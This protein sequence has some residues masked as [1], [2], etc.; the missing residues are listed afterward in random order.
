ME[1]KVLVCF[2]WLEIAQFS[3]TSVLKN[4]NSLNLNAK[5]IRK[6]FKIRNFACHNTHNTLLLKIWMK[7]SFLFNFSKNHLKFL[8][9]L[10]KSL[11][12][13]PLYKKSVFALYKKYD[14]ISLTLFSV[15]IFHDNKM[16][17]I[18]ITFFRVEKYFHRNS[19]VRK[20]VDSSNF[21]LLGLVA[22]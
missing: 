16:L 14:D 6:S 18:R 7:I 5:I 20:S 10:E 15:I 12:F 13:M 21:E 3:F 1:E 4:V 11:F 9:L 2:E 22:M 8:I 17:Y 19:V